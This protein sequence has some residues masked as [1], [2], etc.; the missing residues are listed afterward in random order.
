MLCICL[1]VQ[2]EAEF[3]TLQELHTKMKE[4]AGEESIYT[5]KWLKEKLKDKYGERIYIAE[6]NGKS[7]VVCFKDMVCYH[8]HELWDKQRTKDDQRE[9]ER[10]VITAAKIIMSEIREKQYDISTYPSIRD[11]L[12]PDYQLIPNLLNLFLQVMNKSKLKQRSIGQ[13][14]VQVCKPKSSL[15]PIPLGLAVELDH[16]F[17]SK[18]LIEELPHLG[19]CSS[20]REVSKFKQSSITIVK[21]RIFLCRLITLSTKVTSPHF[22]QC[23][24]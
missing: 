18:W 12:D 1:E 22:S 7:N 6:V 14:I 23:R 8:L 2:S 16:V 17:G 11:I 4:M 9:A 21:G 5:S 24:G 19:F 15:L 20:Y 3:Y 10:V 13:S